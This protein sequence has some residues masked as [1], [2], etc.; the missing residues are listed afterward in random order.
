MS[1]TYNNTVNYISDYI[2]L[3]CERHVVIA[4]GQTTVV[5]PNLLS[6][7]FPNFLLLS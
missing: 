3:D 2:Y 6:I 7:L 4:L 1:I 5:G